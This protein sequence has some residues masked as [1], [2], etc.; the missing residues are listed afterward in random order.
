MQLLE[1]WILHKWLIVQPQFLG[2]CTVSLR[3]PALQILFSVIIVSGWS[4]LFSSA[5]MFIKIEDV[6]WPT[7]VVQLNLVTH[8]STCF[9]HVGSSLT[10]NKLLSQHV[11]CV[12]KR[13]CSL[14]LYND[15]IPFRCAGLLA[16]L[17]K[18]RPLSILVNSFF[19]LFF[20][21]FLL[22]LFK[23]LGRVWTVWSFSH[24]FFC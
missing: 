1:I 2:Y 13:R 24:S 17:N 4:C 12:V 19:F 7:A 6:R 14:F 18:A 3:C 23:F 22:C 11:L 15:Y 10:K 21:F 16:P 8:T 20:L 5:K 9:H